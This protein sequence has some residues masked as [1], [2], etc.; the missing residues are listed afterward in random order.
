M[1]GGEIWEDWERNEKFFERNER[2]F[3]VGGRQW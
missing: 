2:R 1:G 3:A